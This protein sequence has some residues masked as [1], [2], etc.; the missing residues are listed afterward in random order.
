MFVRSLLRK[1]ST[2]AS[3]AFALDIDGVLTRGAK[4]FP[5][6]KSALELLNSNGIPWMLL[7]NGG[8]FDEA[9]RVNKLSKLLN[10]AIR[11]DQFCQSHTPFKDLS[12]KFKTVLV[13]G[14]DAENCKKVAK[15]YGFQDVVQTK[16]ILDYKPEIWPFTKPL[17][18]NKCLQRDFSDVKIDAIFVF[19]DPRYFLQ[20]NDLT[21]EIG[22]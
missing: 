16:E 8:G 10:I 3:C 19:N 6:A 12:R 15:G 18:T 20:G 22:A 13:C 4:S 14:G 21:A 1:Y 5:E 7:T 2:G 17:S 11:E 9:T